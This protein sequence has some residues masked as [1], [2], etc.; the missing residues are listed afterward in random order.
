M[1]LGNCE[2]DIVKFCVEPSSHWKLDT[3]ALPD[4]EV[5]YKLENF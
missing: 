3:V 4:T 1:S 2:E 5:K